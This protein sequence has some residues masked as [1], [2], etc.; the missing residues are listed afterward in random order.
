MQDIMTT[1]RWNQF[2][3]FANAN[4][5]ATELV[6]PIQNEKERQIFEDMTSRLAEMRRIAP[7]A[8]Y[9]NVDMEW[10]VIGDHEGY[11]D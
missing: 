5:S 7:R 4:R 10:G 9:S 3:D 11:Y 1:K 2:I 8:S 6:P